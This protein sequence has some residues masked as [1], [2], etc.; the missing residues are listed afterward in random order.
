MK[1]KEEK[2][3]RVLHITFWYPSK[4]HPGNGTFV[5]EH[6]QAI[7]RFAESKVI[8]FSYL[9]RE[10]QKILEFETIN[11]NGVEVNFIKFRQHPSFKLNF[12]VFSFFAF[13]RFLKNYIY[14]FRPQL[15][16]SHVYIAT[17][18]ATN[19]A[20]L[21]RIPVVATEHFSRIS[22]DKLMT[23][24]K[25]FAVSAFNKCKVVCSVS[26]KLK[27]DLIKLGVKTRIEVVPNA[28]NTDIFFPKKKKVASS[29]KVNMIFVG[30]LI[31]EKG[32][33]ELFKALSELINVID[34]NLEIIGDG[35]ER[36]NLEKYAEEMRIKDKVVFYGYQSKEVVAQKMREASF[37]VHPS[38]FETFGCVVAEA[39]C[40]GT[41]VLATNVG[42]IPEILDDERLGLL[43]EPNDY[44]K[45]RDGIM[46]MI[47]KL[48]EFDKDFIATYASSRYS[49]KVISS[50]YQDIYN[51]LTQKK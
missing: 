1:T 23:L 49:Y 21:F 47:S 45:I 35:P 12:L 10:S 16:H 29:E 19:I 26:N 36:K 46:L 25:K 31:K 39:L 9:P 51:L 6:I 8:A 50:K 18:V 7:S 24:E 44:I 34:F 27:R 43:V 33:Y 14:G 48:P 2:K 30:N 40:C 42:A 32:L 11:D 20:K 3:I 41:P 4:E 38:H 17:I 28:I 13:L 5:R 37:L 22:L 15:V